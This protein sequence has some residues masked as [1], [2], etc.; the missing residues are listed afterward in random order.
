M[1]AVD[2]K[3]VFLKNESEANIANISCSHPS[4]GNH[5]NITWYHNGDLI[6]GVNRSLLT[7]SRGSSILEDVYGVYQCF[8]Y[9]GL[10]VREAS[11]VRVLPYGKISLHMLVNIILHTYKHVPNKQFSLR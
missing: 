1:Q 9:D 3:T 5:G 2:S 10:T 11:M 7:L 6:E 8:S 4:A